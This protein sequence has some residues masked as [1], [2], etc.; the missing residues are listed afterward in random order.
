MPTIGRGNDP[1]KHGQNK[2]AL[3]RRNETEVLRYII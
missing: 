3:V 1:Y 2:D